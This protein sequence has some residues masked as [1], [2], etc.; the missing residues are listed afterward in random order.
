ML[1]V[2]VA[3]SLKLHALSHTDIPSEDFS[4]HSMKAIK[5][6]LG[7]EVVYY[8]A[9]IQIN[10]SSYNKLIIIPYKIL[11]PCKIKYYW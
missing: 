10:E 1:Y 5:L 8:I 6:D 4:I 9:I 3:N 7:L 11:Q 2:H